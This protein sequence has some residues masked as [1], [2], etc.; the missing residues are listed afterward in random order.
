MRKFL[1]A[2]TIFFMLS[3]QV[4]AAQFTR[5]QMD[6]IFIAVEELPDSNLTFELNVETLKEKLESNS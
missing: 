4:E 2:A 1:I 6:K 5:E 3:A